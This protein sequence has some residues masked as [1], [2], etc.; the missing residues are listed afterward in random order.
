MSIK[1]KYHVQ[2]IDKYETKGWILK[3]HYAH[4]MPMAIEHS[5]GLYNENILQGICTFGPTAPPVPITI[6]G[7]YDVCK[8]RELTRL[9]I[10]EGLD[11]NLLSFFVSSCLKKLSRPMCIVSFADKG[12]QHHGYIYQATNFLYTGEGG[13]KDYFL[14]SDNKQMHSLTINDLAAVNKMTQKQYTEKHNIKK[15]KA[16]IK[17]RYI[18]IIGTKKEKKYILNKMLLKILP[19]PKGDNKRYDASYNPDVQLTLY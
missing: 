9:V 16:E 1:D 8:V 15:I 19:Y 18:Q 11:K 6:F 17:Y 13:Q 4:R 10:N 2:S 7:G 14:T 5:F 12:K 3:K